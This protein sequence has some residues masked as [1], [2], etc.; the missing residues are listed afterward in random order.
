MTTSGVLM[1]QTLPT[2]VG[3]HVVSKSTDTLFGK[4][5][6]RTGSRRPARSTRA[7]SQLGI[8]KVHTGKRGGKYVM[9]KGRRIY[10]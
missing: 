2:L 6:R 5:K 9:K 8:K 7:K 3:M 1:T 4:G 10:I